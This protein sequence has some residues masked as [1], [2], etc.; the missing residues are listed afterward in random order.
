MFYARILYDVLFIL[1]DYLVRDASIEGANILE[2][3]NLHRQPGAAYEVADNLVVIN[4]ETINIV[5]SPEV[6]LPEWASSSHHVPNSTGFGSHMDYP[7][8]PETEIF[9]RN[10]AE[11]ALVASSVMLQKKKHDCATTLFPL[12]ELVCRDWV[13]LHRCGAGPIGFM[14]V[15]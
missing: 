4:T 3:S 12:V 11:Q 7:E 8:I 13:V 10:T 14:G 2:A 6:F 1:R 15:T 5:A 9:M